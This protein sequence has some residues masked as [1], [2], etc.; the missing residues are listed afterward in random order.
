MEIASQC[1]NF[2]IILA[3]GKGRRLWPSSRNEMPKQF[4]DFFGTG[5]TLLQLTYQ[6]FTKLLPEDHI[7]VCTS[8]EY[9]DLLRS[10]L[11]AVPAEHILVEPV[12]RNTAPSVAWAT[13]LIKEFQDIF[14]DL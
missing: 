5:T 13:D 2:C 12:N 10:Q 9:Y 4:L 6:R 14:F 7:Y 11:P 3:G 8:A 1:N